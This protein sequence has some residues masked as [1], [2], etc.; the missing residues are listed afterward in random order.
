VARDV[1]L[2]VTEDQRADRFA[3]PKAVLA[4]A[5]M[6]AQSKVSALAH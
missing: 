2:R 5:A 3:A 1:V 4:S 6:R